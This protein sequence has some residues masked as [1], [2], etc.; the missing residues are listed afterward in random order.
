[1]TDNNA[2]SLP[3]PSALRPQ[4]WEVEVEVI[5][6][7]LSEEQRALVIQV[8]QLS[9]VVHMAGLERAKR[10]RHLRE[11]FPKVPPGSKGDSDKDR[12]GWAA[13]LRREFDT[14]AR[15]VNYEIAGIEAADEKLDEIGGWTS[16]HQIF[17]QIGTSHLNEIGRG[18]TP[19]IRA[20]V[21]AK[22]LDGNLTLS[23][24]T[25]RAAVKR[26]NADS[27]RVGLKPVAKPLPKPPASMAKLP[28]PKSGDPQSF[29]VYKEI[30]RSKFGDLPERDQ[31]FGFL[32]GKEAAN[33]KFDTDLTALLSKASRGNVGKIVRIKALAAALHREFKVVGDR[34]QGRWDKDSM[35]PTYMTLWQHIWA[36]DATFHLHDE[37]EAVRKD[38]AE[39]NRHFG[40]AVMRLFNDDLE[41]TP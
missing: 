32:A 14:N 8:K 13:F 7:D 5:S 39:A 20:K 27:T 19:A 38:I 2:I 11:T 36:E 18:S 28:I 6:T 15:D 1:M 37:L 23:V 41:I 29:G 9:A 24:K 16:P 26:L 21:W 4:G 22:L 3:Q 30:S 35:Y 40:I 10:L 33:A 25:I 31:E 17:Q 12:P 34:Y